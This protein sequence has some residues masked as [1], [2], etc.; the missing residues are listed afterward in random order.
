MK[1]LL[2]LLALAVAS[3]G[4]VPLPGAASAVPIQATE[5]APERTQCR[6][7][8]HIVAGVDRSG[9]FDG[10]R[11][12]LDELA[13][14]IERSACP[15]DTVY[16]RFIE[17]NSYRPEAAIATLTFTEV[18]DRP[19]AAA[20]VFDQRNH[21]LQVEHWMRAAQRFA[22]ERR[23]AGTLLRELHPI[24]AGG[25]DVVGFLV[26]ADELLGNA[27]GGEERIV[28]MLTDLQENMDRQAHYTLPGAT[29]I[30]LAFEGE[31]VEE[32]PA[33]RAMWVDALRASGA[34]R[35]HMRDASE[36]FPQRLDELLDTLA[37][38][39]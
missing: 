20:H 13:G 4:C 37:A 22:Q 28:L 24:Q 12:S 14:L 6:A 10:L 35:V 7:P 3:T 39:G 32:A 33:L 2:L 15:G 23:D 29:I 8:R 19:D 21:R 1:T 5:E 31:R 17:E 27:L 26:K 9:S 30:V 16:V 34:V 36:P 11:H 18:P 38:E 25:T